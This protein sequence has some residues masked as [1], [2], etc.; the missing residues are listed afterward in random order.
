MVAKGIGPEVAAG[1]TGAGGAA[2]AAGAAAAISTAG[3]ANDGASVADRVV[4]PSV[5]AGPFWITE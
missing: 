3:G 2:A 1:M 5:A 4:V